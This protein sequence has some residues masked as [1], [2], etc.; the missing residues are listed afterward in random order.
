MK[1]LHF[2]RKG[3]IKIWIIDKATKKKWNPLEF[4]YLDF[5]G[6]DVWIGT[7][8]ATPRWYMATEKYVQTAIAKARS[9]EKLNKKDMQGIMKVIE[10]LKEVMHEDPTS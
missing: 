2:I 9:S 8:Y 3:D 1:I 7:R 4:D 5:G 10:N 6:R